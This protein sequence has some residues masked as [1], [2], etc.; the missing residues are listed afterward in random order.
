MATNTPHTTIGRIV[1]VSY[2]LYVQMFSL[3]ATDMYTPALPDL[4]AFFSASE[5]LVNL[6]LVLFFVFMLIGMLLFGP[7]SDRYGRKPVLYLGCIVYTVASLACAFAPTIWAL[8]ATRIFQALAA[9]MV[10]V[11]GMALIKDCFDGKTRENVLLWAQVAFVLGPIAAPLVGGWVLLFATWRTTFLILTAL[12]ALGFLMTL[13]FRESLPVGERT[14]GSPFSSLKGLITVA[15]S[16]EF[17]LY[18]LISSIFSALPLT[19][20]LIVAPY[21]YENFFGFSAQEYS[22]FFGATAALSTLG[23]LL[24]KLISTWVSLKHLTLALILAAGLSGLTLMCFGHLHVL[25]FFSAMLLPFIVLTMIR[26]Y[27]MNIL[28]GMR[29]TDIGSASSLMSCS[30]NTLGILGTIPVVLIGGHYILII[31]SLTVAG[32]LIALLLWRTL[33]RSPLIVPGIKDK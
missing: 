6:T 12:G 13:A 5:S 23:V 18:M 22:Y 27:S 19:A 9:G 17:T 15:K 7:I 29:T 24:Y 31:G 3:F 26:P 21:I 8:I 30:Y 20:Y 11:V 25:I 14:T 10:Q 2:I 32:T 1:L 16:R 33:M 28:L 4:P